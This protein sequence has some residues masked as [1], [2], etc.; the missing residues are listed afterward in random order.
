M[1]CLNQK[2]NIKEDQILKILLLNKLELE[3]CFF[4]QKGLECNASLLA[5]ALN[6]ECYSFATEALNLF[7]NHSPLSGYQVNILR[8]TIVYHFERNYEMIE[9]MIYFAKKLSASF[10]YATSL[11]IIQ[12]ISYKLHT[13]EHLD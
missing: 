13:C 5:E 7:L 11:K 2:A 12:S 4:L 10:D 9:L 3:A 6:N 8:Q 1:H